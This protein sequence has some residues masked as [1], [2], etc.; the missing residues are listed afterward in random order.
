M[1]FVV[2]Q[3]IDV[4]DKVLG[5]LSVRQFILML[6][7]AGFIFLL[8]KLMSFFSFVVSAV[9]VLFLIF[10]FAFI[11]I[12]G[13][14]FHHFLLSLFMTYRRPQLKIWK[15]DVERYNV[16]GETQ[17]KSSKNKYIP[18]TKEP[19]TSSRLTQLTLVVDTGGSYE[20]RES[21]EEG[22]REENADVTL[23]KI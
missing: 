11:K 19:L 16:R 10:L 7:G 5:P 8:Y 17:P 15:K 6:V 3:F 18:R 9:F 14:P 22:L 20:A 21:E 23:L 1:Q 2:P 4:E 12:N 13:R